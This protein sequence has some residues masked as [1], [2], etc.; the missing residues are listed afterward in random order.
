MR[1]SKADIKRSDEVKPGMILI[2]GDDNVVWIINRAAEH[3]EL[4]EGTLEPL[5]NRLQNKFWAF[6]FAAFPMSDPSKSQKL[7]CLDLI[8]NKNFKLYQ[9]Q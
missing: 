4:I 7:L 2:Y 3:G 9:I 8:L 1:L 6:P 5:D